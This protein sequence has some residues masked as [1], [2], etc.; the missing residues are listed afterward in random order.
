MTATELK[1]R[2]LAVLDEVAEGN[3]VE[4][5]KR[6]HVVAWLVPAAGGR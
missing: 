6:G 2:L 5:T 1:A 4:V 3:E